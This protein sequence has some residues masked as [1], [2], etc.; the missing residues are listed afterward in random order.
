MNTS[1]ASKSIPLW[2]NTRASSMVNAVPLPS[3]L[4]PG[5]GLSSGA[6]GSA[7][8]GGGGAGARGPAVRGGAARQNRDDVSKIDLP[9]DAS[10]RRHLIGVE[11]HLQPGTVAAHLLQDPVAG[12]ADAA[13]RQIRRRQRAARL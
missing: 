13:R 9:R 4:T 11:A 3:S 6:L 10:L 2:L 7:G 5:A 1:V 8:A 12:R